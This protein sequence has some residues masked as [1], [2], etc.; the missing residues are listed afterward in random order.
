[1]GTHPPYNRVAPGG[2]AGYN[3]RPY[4]LTAPP[5]ISPAGKLHTRHPR[6]RPT[7]H[8]RADLIRAGHHWQDR[9]PAAVLVGHQAEASTRR[10]REIA[11]PASATTPHHHARQPTGLVH[12]EHRQA[13]MPPVRD[14]QPPSV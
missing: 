2:M 12:G 6:H 10:N 11:R 9:N 8:R 13:I 3:A 5:R 1:G 14:V 7:C 4:T